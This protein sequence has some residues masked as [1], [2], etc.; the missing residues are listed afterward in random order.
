[1][2]ESLKFYHVLAFFYGLRAGRTLKLHHTRDWSAMHELGDRL[3]T[4]GY[5]YG[6]QILK[7]CEKSRIGFRRCPQSL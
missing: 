3:V 7:W 5:R 6:R 1:M 4:S 2:T